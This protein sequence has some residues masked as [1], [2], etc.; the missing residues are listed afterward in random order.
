MI[1]FHSQYATCNKVVSSFNQDFSGL[2]ALKYHIFVIDLALLTVYVN[3]F[4]EVLSFCVQYTR[5][6]HGQCFNTSLSNGRDILYMT[7]AVKM[8]C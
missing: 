7:L 3:K 2:Y 6:E 1:N 4:N 8:T 5:L